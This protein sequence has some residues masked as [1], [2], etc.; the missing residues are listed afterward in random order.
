MPGKSD[1]AP[2]AAP[3]LGH[4]QQAPTEHQMLPF[5]D[6]ALL[7]R[8][9]SLDLVCIP[10]F[11]DPAR[12]ARPVPAQ[13]GAARSAGGS[14]PARPRGGDRT[15]EQLDHAGTCLKNGG[16]E[17]RKVWGGEQRVGRH[18]RGWDAREKDSLLL[19]VCAICVC[20]RSAC[21]RPSHPIRA[22]NARAF[23]SCP[24]PRPPTQRRRC[25]RSPPLSSR[26]CPC[27]PWSR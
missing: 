3:L 9:V 10:R 19:G 6:R 22:G 16:E 25:T 11:Q 27:C 18:E 8:G 15:I 5:W 17:G 14:G 12:L 21:S 23:V 20:A 13:R 26:A 4:S 7:G 24:K 2:A 1:S